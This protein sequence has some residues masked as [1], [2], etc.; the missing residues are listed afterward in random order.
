[1][2]RSSSAVRLD[3]QHFRV[4]LI[5]DDE[6]FARTVK[7]GLSGV[8]EV[9]VAHHGIEA[10]DWL[11]ADD[12]YDAVLLDLH[13]P[14]LDGISV[15]ERIVTEHPSLAEKLLFVTG[16][17]SPAESE[18][19]DVVGNETLHKPFKMRDLLVAVDRVL[20]DRPGRQ[21]GFVSR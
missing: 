12:R 15:Y 10:L 1:M 13:M 17:Y 21:S 9:V 20:Y 11:D 7:R 2:S 5:D 14:G 3:P 8:C 6:L 4:L 19:L 16:A 18:F